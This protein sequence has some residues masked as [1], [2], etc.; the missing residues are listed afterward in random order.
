MAL[1]WDPSWGY[2]QMDVAGVMAKISPF[3]CMRW[4]LLRLEQ[5]RLPKNIYLCRVSPCGTC[6]RSSS[7]VLGFWQ[8]WRQNRVSREPGGSCIAFLSQLWK[9]R[10]V[11]STVFYKSKQLKGPPK[12]KRDDTGFISWWRIW[13]KHARL[14]IL[15]W[16]VWGEIQSATRHFTDV[17]GRG[18]SPNDSW[19]TVKT[20][21]D[22]FF[23][24][25]IFKRQNIN[26]SRVQVK[27]NDE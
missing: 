5:L 20:K 14:K 3:T 6:I 1:A 22:W 7:G 10:Q 4:R 25:L 27:S 21:Q 18:Q 9:S 24:F 13:S 19:V 2:I 23:F 11:P 15:L 8:S 17:E 26:R 16:P 12:I